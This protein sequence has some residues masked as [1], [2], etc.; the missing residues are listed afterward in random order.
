MTRR[1]LLG[2]VVLAIAVAAVLGRTQIAATASSMVE[3]VSDWS[4]RIRDLAATEPSTEVGLRTIED[5]SSSVFVSIGAAE[6]EAAFA[7]IVSDPSGPP[8]VLV[9]PQDL[10][11]SVPGFG[12]FRLVDALTFGGPELAALSVTNQFGL[13]IDAIAGVPAGSLADGLFGPVLV[14]LS[15]PLFTEQ[16]D[17]AVGRVLPA[18]Q[19]EIA[20]S[21]VEA[22]LVTAGEGDQFEWIQRQGSAWRSVLAAVAA[23]PTVADRFMALAGPAATQ[24]ADLLFTAAGATETLLATIPVG[25]AES[26]TGVEALIPS[27]DQ[28]D[29]FIRSRFAHLLLRPQGRPRLEIL[30]GNGR[31]GTTTEIAA[32]VVNDGFRVVRTDNAD[33]FDYE[34]T[35]I[36][37]QGDH[38]EPWAREILDLLG[39]GLLFL[40]VRAPSGVIDVSI[41]VGQDIPAGEG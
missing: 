18:G 22:L 6:G 8:V 25:R 5:A 35:L 3:T 29:D 32:I 17:G 34:D 7:L 37:A 19:S 16:A 41:I 14:D 4:T 31:I 36:V 26:S 15:V 20:P 2:L 28:V 30:N 24:A 39:R 21:L 12:E 11:L 1:V 38:A 10:L 13:R 40:E 23:A 9:L 33:D 27:A